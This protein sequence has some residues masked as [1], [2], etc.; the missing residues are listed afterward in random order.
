M[1][2]AALTSIASVR[3]VPTHPALNHT[4]N[5][6]STLI[7]E[8]LSYCTMS[9]LPPALDFSATEEEICAQWEKEGTFKAQDRLSREREDEVY[10]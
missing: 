1:L 8:E 9:S 7:Q 4:R 10:T 2:F 6:Y 5:T 3:L